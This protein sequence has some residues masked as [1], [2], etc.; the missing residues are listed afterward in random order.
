MSMQGEESSSS[1]PDMVAAAPGTLN[2]SG[3]SEFEQRGWSILR[4]AGYWTVMRCQLMREALELD[5]TI[6]GQRRKANAGICL[7][8]EL[9][10]SPHC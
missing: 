8:L 1:F 2:S 6:G 7:I 3:R 4:K 10:P 9:T 5:V